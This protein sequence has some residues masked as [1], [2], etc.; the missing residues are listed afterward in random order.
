MSRVWIASQKVF[1]I[2]CACHSSAVTGCFL[3][4]PEVCVSPFAAD[5]VPCLETP[6]LVCPGLKASE[7]S[8]NIPLAPPKRSSKKLGLFFLV[9]SSTIEKVSLDGYLNVAV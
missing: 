1:S 3:F 6:E 5:E 9:E 2:P 4:V 7:R 8:R